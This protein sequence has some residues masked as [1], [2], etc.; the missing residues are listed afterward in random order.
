MKQTQ[1]RIERL[2]VVEEP[3]KKWELRMDIAIAPR[4]GTVVATLNAALV[5]RSDFT[6]GPV[7]T[8][9]NWGDRILLTGPNGSGKTTL[10]AVLLG[11]L[12][13]DA[14]TA[15]LGSGI[16]IGEIDQT[17]RL[18]LGERSLAAVFVPRFRHFPTTRCGPGWRSSDC[19]APAC[20]ARQHRCLLANEP[21]RRWPYL[22]PAG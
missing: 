4:S 11:R 17:R 8:Q 18:F 9:V 22:R 5:R 6:L 20:C 19:A 13:P 16:A 15:R 21:V 10:L 12:A 7:T 3:R 1:R 14:G 2:D